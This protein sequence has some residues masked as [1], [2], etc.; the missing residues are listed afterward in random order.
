MGPKSTDTLL[1]SSVS[2]PQYRALEKE[3]SRDEIANFIYER[4]NERYIRPFDKNAK[5]NGFIMMASACLMI[6]SLES[7]WQGWRKSPT[8]ALAFC[9]FFDRNDRFRAFRGHSQKF[10]V[11]IRCGILHQG[12]T[13]GG[14]HIR[15]DRRVLFEPATTTIDATR[16]LKEMDCCLSEYCDLLRASEWNSDVWKNLRKKMKAVCA[17]AKRGA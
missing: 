7:F 5:K 17:N 4:F 2:V 9:Q 10:Y 14:W 15:R 11:N 12:E 3:G 16:F 1:S 6:E 8:S 13:T